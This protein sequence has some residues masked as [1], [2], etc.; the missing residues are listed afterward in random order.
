M[1]VNV[2]NGNNTPSPAWNTPSPAACSKSSTFV[3]RATTA[4]T[5]SVGYSA[6][7]GSASCSTWREFHGKTWWETW[8][9]RGSTA[10][11]WRSMGKKLEKTDQTW[12]LGD[13]LGW[14]SGG[15]HIQVE[16]I[17]K[18]K[19]IQLF[20]DFLE[21]FGCLGAVEELQ[22]AGFGHLS[23][24]RKS[25][26]MNLKEEKKHQ[27][28]SQKNTLMILMICWFSA[29]CDKRPNWIDWLTLF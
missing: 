14:F 26:G 6:V 28:A 29:I 27:K 19:F 2:N 9:K 10:E 24:G 15:F 3:S 25:T 21:I 11:R 8:G 23:T 22:I 1:T 13:W 16:D 4:K 7:S 18:V 12:E 17:S 5:C 20:H